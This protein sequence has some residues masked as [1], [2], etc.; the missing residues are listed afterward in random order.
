LTHESIYTRAAASG[1]ATFG[2]D[3]FDEAL[4]VT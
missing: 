1:S 3:T 4:L 2:K